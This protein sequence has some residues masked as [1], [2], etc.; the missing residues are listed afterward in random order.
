MF[1]VPR[2]GCSFTFVFASLSLLKL[3]EVSHKQHILKITAAGSSGTLFCTALTMERLF[4]PCTRL[5]K[6]LKSQGV[7]EEPEAPIP[8]RL[9]ELNLDVSTEELLSAENASTYADLYAMLGDM[10][11]V[12]WLTPHAAV[13]REHQRLVNAFEVLDGFY[14][15]YFSAD[16]IDIVATAR[17]LEHLFE[18]CDVVVRL[19]AGSVVQSVCVSHWRSLDGF[20]NAPTLAYLM[21]QCQSLKSLTLKRLKMDENHIRV[22][23]AYS[24]PGLEIV[25][26]YCRLTSAGASA[27]V[28]VLG[29]NQGPTKLYQCQIDNFVFANGLRANS[30]LKSLTTRTSDNLEVRDR[31]LL[32]ISGALRENKGLVE[33]NLMCDGVSVNDETWGVICDSLNNHPTLEVLNLRAAGGMAALAPAVLKSRIQALVDMLK[34]NMSIR[35]IHLNDCY[36]QHEFYSIVPY[37]ETNRLRPRVHAI[38]KTRP[39]PYRVKV[40]G[41]ALFAVRTDPNH[42]WMLLSGNAEV[43]FPSTAAT[44]TSAANLPTTATAAA[45]SNATPV[46]ATAAVIVTATHAASATSASAAAHVASPTAHQKRKARP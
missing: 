9:Q 13:A 31:E 22:L 1:H 21:E 3:L 26:S 43:A 2:Y 14:P 25:L 7:L 15:F 11:T 29:R 20:I 12:A 8:E 38:Q 35:T 32:E 36:S 4:S 17:S 45:T 44:T 19:L 27:L 46:A 30:R 39:I 6:I 28:D 41:R 37:L 33:L 40:L 5:H 10:N 34:I 16:G 18:I 42:F 23:G 24:R